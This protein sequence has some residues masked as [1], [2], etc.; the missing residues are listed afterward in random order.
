ME[1]DDKVP[2]Y[3]Q[4]ELY[5]RR[6]IIAGELIPGDKLPP[7]RQLAVDLTVNVNTIQRALG[8]LIQAGILVSKRGLG[9]FVTDDSA[10]LSGIREAAIEHE[11]SRVYDDLSALGLSAAQMTKALREYIEKRGEASHE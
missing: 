9:N 1:F 2:I 5:I 6:Q 7:V 11:L 4:I 8:A 10:V 3:Y